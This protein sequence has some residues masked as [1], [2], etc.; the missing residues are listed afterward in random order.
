MARIKKKDVNLVINVEPHE[1]Q[2]LIELIELL[3]HEWYVQRGK[4]KAGA[5]RAKA[6]FR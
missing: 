4:Q 6:D 5:Y 1:A 3:F 2:K